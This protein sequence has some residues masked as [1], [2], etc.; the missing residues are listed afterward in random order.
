MITHQGSSSLAPPALLARDLS[1]LVGDSRN[2]I[3][4]LEDLQLTVAQGETVAIVGSSGSGKST[5]LGILAGLDVPTAG[6]VE[7]Q[8]AIFSE[9]DEDSRAAVRGRRMGWRGSFRDPGSW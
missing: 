4:V 7:V 8:G 2:Q 5:L 6:K 3:K 1:K 9:L